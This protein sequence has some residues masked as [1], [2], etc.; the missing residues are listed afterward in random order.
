MRL[1]M[2]RIAFQA[3][4]WGGML[5][6]AVIAI[7]VGICFGVISLIERMLELILQKRNAHDRK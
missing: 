7:P 5:L 3:A 1:R 6:V 4:F 2:R